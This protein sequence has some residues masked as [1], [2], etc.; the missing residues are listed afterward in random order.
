M[1][2]GVGFSCPRITSHSKGQDGSWKVNVLAT[3]SCPALYDP[4]E[5]SPPGSSIHGILQA[6]L[7]EWIAISSSTGSFQPRD[8][9][10]VFSIVGRFF[11]TWATREAQKG[12]YSLPRKSEVDHLLFVLKYVIMIVS[13]AEAL[14]PLAVGEIWIEHHSTKDR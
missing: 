14:C 7:L 4:M 1:S 2:L 5:C 12:A 6:K 13:A 10:Q 8:R 3:Q 9:T 11:T